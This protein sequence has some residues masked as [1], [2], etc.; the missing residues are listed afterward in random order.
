MEKDFKQG[1][2]NHL[3][4]LIITFKNLRMKFANILDFLQNFIEQANIFAELFDPDAL[5]VCLF[6]SADY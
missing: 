6:V 5:M 4:T 3:P 1:Q 2:K